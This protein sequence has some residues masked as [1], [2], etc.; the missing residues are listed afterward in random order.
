MSG[1]HADVF[2]LERWLRQDHETGFGYES[3]LKGMKD[4]DFTFGYG[5]RFYV[6]RNRAMAELHEVTSA[7]NRYDASVS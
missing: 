1:N 7:V 5:S 3:R 6:G 4:A 2:R